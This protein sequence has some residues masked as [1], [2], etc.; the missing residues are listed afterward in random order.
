MRGRDEFGRMLGDAD[1]AYFISHAQLLEQ[2]Q[3]GRQQG[4]ANVKARVAVLV[5]Q[6]GESGSGKS[7]LAA[8]VIG[9]LPG[10]GRVTDGTIRFDGEDITRAPSKRRQELRGSSIG[11]VP[12]DLIEIGRAS[13][14]ERV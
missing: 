10:T 9:L 1:G 3:V 7:T 4:F 5:Q 12:Q 14:R 6:Q 13:C 11:L 8:A 2:R